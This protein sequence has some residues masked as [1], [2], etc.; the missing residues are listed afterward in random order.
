MEKEKEKEKIDI[1][2]EKDKH[3]IKEQNELIERL[4]QELEEHAKTLKSYIQQE[5]ARVSKAP[6]IVGLPKLPSI[7]SI[8]NMEKKIE[9]T[10]LINYI[11]TKY[12][13]TFDIKLLELLTKFPK[14]KVE[15]DITEHLTNLE[16]T[17]LL[18]QPPIHKQALISAMAFA[19]EG[20]TYDW[21]INMLSERFYDNKSLLWE[22]IKQEIIAHFQTAEDL[23]ILI[24]KLENLRMT[25]TAE[26]YSKEFKVISDKI[27]L[28]EYEQVILRAYRNGLRVD[29]RE[30]VDVS[31]S[32]MRLYG[33]MNSEP[34]KINLTF[35]MK[36]AKQY[37]SIVKPVEK[38]RIITTKQ[39]KKHCEYCNK[40]YHDIN[41][42]RL[43]QRNESI[44]CY[45][46]KERG[47]T[48]IMCQKKKLD[49][50]KQKK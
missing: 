36:M 9:H 29:V 3:I 46:C 32:S 13:I 35:L 2:L 34:V 16:K 25:D 47:H 4:Q 39:Q 43:K 30:R 24:N 48:S 42:C 6:T 38:P 12:N 21:Y 28:I 10:D 17:L 26:N 31:E 8:N 14:Y 5:E 44:T 11:N 19:L 20:D 1:N 33:A 37:D 49:E 22:D 40:D 7:S 23:N 50:E 18:L 15:M 27:K 41:E 45:Y